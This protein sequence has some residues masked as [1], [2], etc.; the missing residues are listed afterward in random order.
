M[1]DLSHILLALFLAAY[2]LVVPI[3]WAL[4]RLLG[5]PGW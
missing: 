1:T 3:A 5:R 2:C 4:P